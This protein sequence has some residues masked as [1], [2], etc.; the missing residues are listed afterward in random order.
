MDS[1]RNLPSGSSAGRIAYM[2]CRPAAGRIAT[3]LKTPIA[4]AMAYYW[5]TTF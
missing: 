5:N 2:T 1:L 4:T 3:A